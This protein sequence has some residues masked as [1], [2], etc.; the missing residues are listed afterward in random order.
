MRRIRAVDWFLAPLITS[1]V[2]RLSDAA[3]NQAS[4][5]KTTMTISPTHTFAPTAIEASGA[6][7]NDAIEIVKRIGK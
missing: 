3:G 1:I 5:F 2:L 4:T 7:N 6:W